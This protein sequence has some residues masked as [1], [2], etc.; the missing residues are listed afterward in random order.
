MGEKHKYVLIKNE[1]GENRM[2]CTICA[3]RL[4]EEYFECNGEP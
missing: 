4:T 2:R 3:R 1:D